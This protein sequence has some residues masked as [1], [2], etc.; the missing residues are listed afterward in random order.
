METQPKGNLPVQENLTVGGGGV[1]A[2]TLARW[3]FQ[4]AALAVV[5]SLIWMAAVIALQA[6]PAVQKF[7]LGFLVNTDWDP[8]SDQ[9]GGLA[10]VYGTIASSAIAMLIAVPVGLGVAIFLTE[11]FLPEAVLTPLAFMVELLAAIP[12]VVYGLWGIFVLIPGLTGFMTWVSDS[13]GWVQINGNPVFGVP[14]GPGLFTAGVLLAIMI[15]PT[16]ASISRDVLRA[17]PGSLRNASLALGAT[18]WETIFKVMLPA[19]SS[20]LV[21]ASVLALGRALGETMAVTMVIGNTPQIDASIFAPAYTISALLANEFAEANNPLHIGALFFAGLL[22]FG[23]T[24]LVNI[25]AEL[26]VR[27]VSLERQ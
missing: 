14:Y 24:L 12:S 21:G 20:G 9:F 4:G 6:L 27:K 11:D 8:V 17:L 18:R 22:L 5:G 1:K 3:L 15:L 19:A 10:F 23:V 7:G 2:D 13:F 26:F 25:L 16:I